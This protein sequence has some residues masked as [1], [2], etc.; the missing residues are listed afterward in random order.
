MVVRTRSRPAIYRSN[1]NGEQHQQPIP[2]LTPADVQHAISLI[3]AAYSE[4]VI[5]AASAA[6]EIPASLDKALCTIR[7]ATQKILRAALA[8][9]ALAQSAKISH[10]CLE[11]LIQIGMELSSSVS[12]EYV[13]LEREEGIAAMSERFCLSLRATGD[14]CGL[15]PLL[16]ALQRL[17]QL[18]GGARYPCDVSGMG[19]RIDDATRGGR[20]GPRGYTACLFL[21]LR[22]VEALV[23]FFYLT[24]GR[25]ASSTCLRASPE[26]PMCTSGSSALDA[27]VGRSR[28]E[29]FFPSSK[30]RLR[31]KRPCLP[32][33]LQ[34]ELW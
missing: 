7:A 12:A 29:F 28:A 4:S 22:R 23:G 2:V 31:R 9:H 26:C 16:N 30:L 6:A 15:S 27:A 10:G 19:Y 13:A 8:L 11:V 34:F 3:Q 32:K 20:R 14:D 5:Q 24:P 18:A 1:A 25:A 33:A 17:C 21:S